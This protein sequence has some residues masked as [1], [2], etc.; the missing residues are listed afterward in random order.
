MSE[1]PYR[2]ATPLQPGDV[3]DAHVIDA[4]PEY[5]DVSGHFAPLLGVTVEAV[6]EGWVRVRQGE[7]TS[8]LK[9]GKYTI[10]RAGGEPPG[11]R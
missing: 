3:I 11:P 6:G 7:S 9:T 4:P 2:A 1:S 10:T 5:E 8:T